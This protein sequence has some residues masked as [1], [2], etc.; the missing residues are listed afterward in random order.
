[1]PDLGGDYTL[2]TILEEMQKS[3]Y[4]GTEIG[5]KFPEEASSLNKVL[6]KYKLE[7]ASAWHST[8]FLSNTVDDELEKIHKKASLLADSGAAIINLAE[9]TGSV[10]GEMQSPISSKPVCSENDWD[11]LTDSLNK[12]GE[13]CRSYG[14]S[15]A[16][17]HHMGTCIQSEEEIF[18]LLSS[19]DSNLVNLC[20]DTGHL[21][22]AGV[23]PVKFFDKNM[24]RI[25]HIHFKDLRPDV[26]SNINFE[27]ISFLNAVLSGV[28][29]VPGDGCIDFESISKSIDISEYNG[30]IIVEAEQDPS[31]A[32]PFEY[33]M[34]SKKYLN[35]IWSN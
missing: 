29:T 25:R 27:K 26:F 3:G 11:I 15:V 19:T 2:D 12:A 32:N 17:H 14:V 31:K 18:K 33:A 16:Y 34:R 21:F 10:H 24:D 20:A 8:F 23:N 9:C 6:I 5:N 22:F 4:S 30:W 7:L 28:F 13:I 1:M 35:K